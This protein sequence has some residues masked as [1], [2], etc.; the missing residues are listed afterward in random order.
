MSDSLEDINSSVV[1]KVQNVE[2]IQ[3][4]SENSE[5]VQKASGTPSNCSKNTT[6]KRDELF[7]Q[8]NSKNVNIIISFNI[9]N[10]F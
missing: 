1:V 3:P 8:Y 10:W 5:S 7:E 2:N 9:L 4:Q 6:G